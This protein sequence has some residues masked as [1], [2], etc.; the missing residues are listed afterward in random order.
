[1]SERLKLCL[2]DMN[3]GLP[4]QATRCFRRI[5]DS[6]SK[7]VREVNPGL[8]IELVHVQPRNK[9]ELPPA[10]SDLILSSG[11]PGAP[12]DG[13]EDAWGLGYRRFLDRVVERNQLDATRAPKLF[14]VCH[15]FQIAA[16]HF[17]VA[18]VERREDLKFGVFPSY[19]TESGQ[20]T[21]LFAPFEDR[22]FTWEHRAW[23]VVDLDRARLEAL[24]GAVLARESRPGRDDKGR[25][26]T[27]LSFAPGIVG[28]QFHPEADLPGVRAWVEKPENAA[29]LT[30]AYGA[31]LYKRM[32]TTLHDPERLG[33]TFSL[34]IPGWLTT[35]FNT[36]AIARDLRP[37]DQPVE[38]PAAF[39][40]PAES[41]HNLSICPPDA[42]GA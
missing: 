23:H 32:V 31:A 20:Q 26:L 3:D 33:K 24:G 15:S 16:I 37:I 39:S 11:G 6:F 1:M 2:V 42:S 17:D 29:D 28:T 13:L 22:L 21:P 19:T 8:S 7:R 4:N 35:Q 41:E 9:G 18:K 34:V 10:D 36:W 30:D 5:L 38:D 12:S 27:A 40:A 14:A 25:A